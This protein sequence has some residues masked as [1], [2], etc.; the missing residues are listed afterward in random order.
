[1][2]FA[3][4]ARAEQGENL[5]WANLLSDH[6]LDSILSAQFCGDLQSRRFN[7]SL[8][9]RVTAEQRCDLAAQRIISVAGLCEKGSPGD[10]V[11]LQSGVIEPLDMSPT[12]RRHSGSSRRVHAK[13]RI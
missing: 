13:A 2:D 3:H 10:R 11:A 8:G 12:F 7:E 4:P 1:M 5:I 6:G 9:A